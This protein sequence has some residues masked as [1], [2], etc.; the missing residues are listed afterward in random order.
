MAEQNEIKPEVIV[1]PIKKGKTKTF[2]QYCED[3][4]F[5]AKHKAYIKGKVACTVCGKVLAR[6]NM[7]AHRKTKKCELKGKCA[8]SDKQKQF[9][10]ALAL[11]LENRHGKNGWCRINLEYLL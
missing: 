9:E 11:A 2:K 5:K 1:A 3:P 4:A 6:Y 7:S 10:E 8:K